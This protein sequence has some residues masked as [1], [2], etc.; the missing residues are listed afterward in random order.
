MRDRKTWPREP[1]LTPRTIAILLA[2]G[3]KTGGSEKRS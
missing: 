3:D 1:D 2:A